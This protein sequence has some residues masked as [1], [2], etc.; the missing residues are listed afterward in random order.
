M[1]ITFLLIIIL[2]YYFLKSRVGSNNILSPNIYSVLVLFHLIFHVYIG[3]YLIGSGYFRNSVINQISNSDIII[4]TFYYISASIVLLFIGFKISDLFFKNKSS[5]AFNNFLERPLEDYNKKGENLLVFIFKIL[6]ISCL[7]S[8]LYVTYITGEIPFIKLLFNSQSELLLSRTNFNQNFGGLKIIK[9]L[10]FEQLTP[11]LCLFFYAIK[12]KDNSIKYWFYL[13]LILSV[14]SAI[15]S[16]A[17]SPLIVL[18]INLFIVKFYLNQRI[19][20]KQL[21]KFII[22]LF[23]L[24]I[25]IIVLASGNSNFSLALEY[26]FNRI[27]LDE[28]SGTFLMFDIY[29]ST[30][31]HIYFNSL[32]EFLSNLFGFEKID[33]AQ[34]TSMLY[35]F[36]ERA[37]S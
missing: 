5:T 31:D 8:S 18:M 12:H 15:Y 14:Y 29:P 9:N 24:I 36:G 6:L 32:S 37:E 16:G 17:K 20:T 33:N 1:L 27:F 30:Y 23:I 28:V 22:I 4:D 35:A 19:S 25:I 7:M 11:L 34:R 3:A 21:F 13:S 26:L 10:F 2:S